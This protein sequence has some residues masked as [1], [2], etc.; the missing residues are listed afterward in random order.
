[1]RTLDILIVED[2]ISFQV[3]LEMQVKKI[4]YEV[5]KCVDNSAEAL[6][7]I[8]ENPPDLILMDIH[9]KG[10]LN[11]VELAEKIKHLDI[12]I[13]FITSLTDE[14]LYDQAKSTNLIGYLVK[15]IDPL[16]LRSSIE[17]AVRALVERTPHPEVGPELFEARN[18]FFFLKKKGLLQKVPLLEI[19]Y[20]E[21]DGDYCH[22]HT[23]ASIF[24]VR[25]PLARL[26]PK[27]PPNDFIQVHKKYLAHLKAV[28]KFSLSRNELTTSKGLLPVGRVF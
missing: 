15:P 7:Q 27:F 10:Q 18:D 9:I 26:I 25:G 19:L 21:A 3:E 1:M 14:E 4:G 11:G 5:S 20:V 22:I 24:T 12:P 2:N 6:E 8:H 23:Q 16:T 17:L 13:L 28:E